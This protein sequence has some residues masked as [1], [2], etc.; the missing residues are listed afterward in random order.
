VDPLGAL[1]A[2]I[3]VAVYPG[4]AFLLLVAVLVAMA[5]GAPRT[6]RINAVEAAGLLAATVAAALAPLPGTVLST[7]PPPPAFGPPTNLVAAVILEAA[8]VTLMSRERWTRRRLLA[9]AAP[10]LPLF[11]LSAAAATLSL[12][13]LVSL[14][15]GIVTAARALIAGALVA[16]APVLLPRPVR[17]P[18][19]LVVLASVVI[20]ASSLALGPVIGGLPT[21]LA[22]AVIAAAGLVYGL[23]LAVAWRLPGAQ[24]ALTVFAAVQ[25][26]AAVAA[27]LVARV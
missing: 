24:T 22:A 5:A 13:I 15:G 17:S 2:A 8:A 1:Q 23:I 11:L 26:A 14:P 4:G 6:L 18:A 3:A 27:V 10:L 21:P 9:A 20:L 16:A 12:Q 19:P 7:L 25:G